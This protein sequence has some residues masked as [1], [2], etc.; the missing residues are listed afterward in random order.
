M[1]E[2]SIET[3]TGRVHLVLALRMET[4]GVWIKFIVRS[5]EGGL[6]ECIR[7]QSAHVVCVERKK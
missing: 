2:F 4:E 3:V 1:T 6:R 7:F 5:P